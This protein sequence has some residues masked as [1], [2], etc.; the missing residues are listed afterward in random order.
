MLG[1]TRRTAETNPKHTSPAATTASRQ[2]R[3][4]SQGVATAGTSL[5]LTAVAIDVTQSIV[6]LEE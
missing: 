4:S 6:Q 2:S 5:G 1:A 3:P